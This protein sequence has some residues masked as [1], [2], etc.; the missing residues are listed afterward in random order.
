MVSN[1]AI[2]VRSHGASRAVSG[3]ERS[4]SPAAALVCSPASL[5]CEDGVVEAVERARACAV[6]EGSMTEERD[7]V[8]AEVPNRGVDHAVG[9][10][11]HHSAND[12]SGENVIPDIMLVIILWLGT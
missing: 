12:R 11:S 10:E 7:V 4:A 2:R 9:A 1:R 5:A 6:D 8:E 3:I